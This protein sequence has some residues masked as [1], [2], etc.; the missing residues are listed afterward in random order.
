MSSR[1]TA[2]TDGGADADSEHQGEEDADCD[3]HVSGTRRLRGGGKRRELD[4]RDGVPVDKSARE[5]EVCPPGTE[6]EVAVE[7]NIGRFRGARLKIRSERD[8]KWTGAKPAGTVR[9]R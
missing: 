9:E 2:T 7:S 6:W 8:R 1:K 5:T 3:E 4:R